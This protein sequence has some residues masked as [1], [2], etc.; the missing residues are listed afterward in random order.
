LICYYPWDIIFSE[1][2]LQKAVI[3]R[4]QIIAKLGLSWKMP[5]VYKIGH[6]PVST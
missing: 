3:P 6:I 1:D 2:A 4:S 5:G